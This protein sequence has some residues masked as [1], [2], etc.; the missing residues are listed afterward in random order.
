MNVEKDNSGSRISW[1]GVFAGTGFFILAGFELI[2]SEIP[3]ESIWSDPEWLFA[4]RGLFMWGMILLPSFVYGIGWLRGFPAWSY[5]YTALAFFF[6]LY[7]TRSSTPG[8]SFFGYPT[9]ERQVWGWR[10]WVPFLGATLIALLLTRSL[11]PLSKFFINGWNDWTLFSFCLFGS[12]PL[13]IAISFDEIDRLYSLY[14]MVVLTVLMS[15]TALFYLLSRTITQRVLSL[16]LGILIILS[17]TVIGVAAYWSE[18][19]FSG[20]YVPAYIFIYVLFF[21]LRA[22]IG[23]IRRRYNKNYP[24]P[25]RA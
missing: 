2:L 12:M 4:M 5:P 25:E 22:L 16:A 10:A 6:S 15:L 19:T 24:A 20:V 11:R 9:F 17:L 23:L 21:S 8:L 3:H 14:F 13:L 7:L 1:W 18:D